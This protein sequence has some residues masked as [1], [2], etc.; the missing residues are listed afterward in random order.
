MSRPLGPW[1]TTIR[2]TNSLYSSS[3]PSA[4]GKSTPPLFS[5]TTT[6]VP[7]GYSLE[8]PLLP[9]ILTLPSRLDLSLPEGPVSRFVQVR[10]SHPPT[11]QSIR[12]FL[13]VVGCVT[14]STFPALLS[15]RQKQKEGGRLKGRLQTQSKVSRPPAYNGALFITQCSVIWYYDKI[16]KIFS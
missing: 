16:K 9:S 12:T 4:S 5:Y 7:T 14:T 6:P 11:S 2:R 10:T 15:S 13:S 1:V 8:H 3:L